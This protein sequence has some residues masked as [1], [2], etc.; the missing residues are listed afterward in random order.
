MENPA[1]IETPFTIEFTVV[2]ATNVFTAFTAAIIPV[3]M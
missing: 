2:V 3:L 1:N